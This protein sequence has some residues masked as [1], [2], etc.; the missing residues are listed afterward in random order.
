MSEMFDEFL[1][2]NKWHIVEFF[3]DGTLEIGK[4]ESDVSD[5]THQFIHKKDL[6]MWALKHIISNDKELDEPC[7]KWNTK[8]DVEYC[9]FHMILLAIAIPCLGKETFWKKFNELK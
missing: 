2:K 7:C 6:G 5:E 4:E 8:G 9:D 3:D 1:K